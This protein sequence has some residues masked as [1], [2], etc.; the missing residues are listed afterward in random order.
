MKCIFQQSIWSLTT[1]LIN[2]VQNRCQVEAYD[3]NLLPT[4]IGPVFI[5]PQMFK[6]NK[7]HEQQLNTTFY[8]NN[9]EKT[10]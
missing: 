1:V 9:C 3:Q 8:G 5:R 6:W 10:V 2:I 4:Y 7:I